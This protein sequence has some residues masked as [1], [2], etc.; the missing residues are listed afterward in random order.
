MTKEEAAKLLAMIKIAYPTSYRDLD[1]DSTWATIAMWQNTFS[2]VP[3]VILTLA[4]ENF[5]RRSKYP[6]T[7]AEM[8]EELKALYYISAHDVQTS[9][10]FGEIDDRA[11]FVFKQT[12]RFRGGEIERSINYCNI[13]KEMLLEAQ[14]KNLLKEG[15]Q[16]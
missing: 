12:S 1:D 9:S 5:R 14:E 3:Y 8:Y 10:F 7:I 11:L 4:F 13:T 6:P 2:D 16:S 15:V